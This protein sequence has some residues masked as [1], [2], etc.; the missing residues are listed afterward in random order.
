MVVDPGKIC[1]EALKA[2]HCA[3]R[4]ALRQ[5]HILIEDDMLILHKPIRGSASYMRLQIVPVG[6]RDILFVPFHLNP[7]GGHLNVYH[8]L[9]RLCMPY[10]WPEMYSYVKRMCHTCPGCALLNPTCGSSSE[11]IYHFPIEAPFCVLFVDT[12][13][14]GKY[15][16]FEGSEVYLVAA[17]GMTGFSTME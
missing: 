1:K 16:G 11:L 10:H 15:S 12:Y 14:A 5:S 17:Y 7:I 4:H 2:V 9:H 8:T 6:L 13:S 3:Y